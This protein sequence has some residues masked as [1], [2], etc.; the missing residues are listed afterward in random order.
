MIDKIQILFVIGLVLVQFLAWTLITQAFQMLGL[1][2]GETRKKSLLA[3][4]T[5]YELV[6][7]AN[8]VYLAYQGC[9]SVFGQ[10]EASDNI[11]ELQG[12][13]LF[14]GSSWIEWLVHIIIPMLAYQI[15][16]FLIC[17]AITELRS[18]DSLIHHSLTAFCSACC[19]Y[20]FA[21]AHC[22]S[23][24]GVIEFSTIPL[25][26]LDIWKRSP[27]LLENHGWVKSICQPTF[28]ILFILVRLVYLPYMN[29][30][31]W[32]DCYYAIQGGQ[33]LPLPPFFYPF[34]LVNTVM[35]LLQF[36]W[37]NIIVRK[38]LSALFPTDDNKTRGSDSKSK[39]K[40]S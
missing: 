21:Q 39:T 28:A 1:L 20:P 14:M 36:Y 7:L 38:L 24:L 40:T 30:F 25:S 19:M 18:P 15:W 27:F 29:H 12:N 10:N 32:L 16:N 33:K 17:V 34:V 13:R 5:A 31:F 23:L 4:C 37:G 3:D 26:F 9:Y 11:L 22:P 6:A 35:V 2:K 8:V